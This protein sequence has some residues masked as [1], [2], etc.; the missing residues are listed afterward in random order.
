MNPA[1]WKADDSTLAQPSSPAEANLPS[2]PLVASGSLVEELDRQLEEWRY[3]LPT[4]LAFPGFSLDTDQ[5]VMA[6][7]FQYRATEARLKGH[8]MCRYYSAKSVIYRSFLYNVLHSD[9]PNQLAERDQDGARIAVEA[10]L[11]S[12]LHSGLLHEPLVLLLHPINSWR[13]CVG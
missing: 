3:C 13:T 12:T 5:Q 6:E 10:A 2:L 4:S 8:L 11:L 7:P 9:D 1:N